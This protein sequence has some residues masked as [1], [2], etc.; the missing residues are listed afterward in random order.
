M[1]FTV[2]Q[3]VHHRRYDYRGVVVSIDRSCKADEDWYDH[4]RTQPKRDQPWYH[5]LRHE[6]REHY[7]A[8]ENLEPDSTGEEVDHPYVDR[9]FPTFRNGRY[10]RESFN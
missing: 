2:G 6:G 1:K 9:I 5:V 7:V 10:Y 8:E 3:L 4:N